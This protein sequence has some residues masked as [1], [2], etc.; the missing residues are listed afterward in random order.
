MAKLTQDLKDKMLRDW[1]LG[2]SQNDIVK[3]YGVSK[4]S[5]NKLCKG[6]EQS[7]QPLVTA[8]ADINQKL[9]ELN[10]LEMTAFRDSVTERT[11]HL[12]YFQ[13]SALKNQKLANKI[14]EEKENSDGEDG[15]NMSMLESHARTTAR[16]KETVLG[17]E[18]E[19]QINVQN[20][21][22]VLEPINKADY[23]KVRQ[24]MLDQDDC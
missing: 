17:K 15:L 3:T 23:A 10:E 16:N 4:G 19:T 1:K 14:I 12:I 8:Q 18:P 9:T 7:I 5:V 21:N 20:N 24:S 13:N 11:K 2:K 6:V 22:A